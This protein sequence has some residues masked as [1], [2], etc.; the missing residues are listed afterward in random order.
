MEERGYDERVMKQAGE[1][2]ADERLAEFDRLNEEAHVFSSRFER[3][4]ERLFRI[5][6]KN[7]AGERIP[8]R[9]ALRIIAVCAAAVVLMTVSVMAAP[10][11]MLAEAVP[12]LAE[13]VPA[14]RQLFTG[15]SAKVTVE[16]PSLS[17]LL[18]RVEEMESGLPIDEGKGEPAWI[19]DGYAVTS[20]DEHVDGE[21]AG[22]SLY[23]NYT[24][25]NH[26]GI[27]F[28]RDFVGNGSGY[29]AQ[30]R[31]DYRFG[32]AELETEP[33][34]IGPYEG[35]SGT[36]VSSWEKQDGGGEETEGPSV[37]RTLL[38]WS[39]GRY[40]YRMEALTT[41]ADSSEGS[42]AAVIPLPYE[43]LLRMAESMYD[44]PEENSAAEKVPASE[45]DLCPG[46]GKA[47]L[48][49]VCSHRTVMNRKGDQKL[50]GAIPWETAGEGGMK[51][52]TLRP[53]AFCYTDRVCPACGYTEP[54]EG[55]DY[56][57]EWVGSEADGKDNICPFGK[58]E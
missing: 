4:K 46:C 13:V 48:E 41:E 37:K 34:Q 51:D 16:Q 19:P 20:R 33:V 44:P 50:T 53:A 17:R 35:T 36:I 40:V 39:A 2:L 6:Q 56:H 28:N 26:T 49:E 58:E 32:N 43:D 54:G 55:T 14:I 15:T 57:T 18:L 30:Y 11:D 3:K 22:P 38:V 5:N 12:A 25:W 23:I 45:G 21:M 42:G 10:P 27:I 29:G 24:K 52:I 1:R 7:G 8:M 9:R 47:V 31:A